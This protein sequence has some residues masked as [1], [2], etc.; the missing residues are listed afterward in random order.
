ML[1]LLSVQ[2]KQHLQLNTT[3]A[4]TC[5]YRHQVSAPS[6]TPPLHYRQSVVSLSHYTLHTSI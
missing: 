1:C 3:I 5:T 6:R 2:Y 4:V